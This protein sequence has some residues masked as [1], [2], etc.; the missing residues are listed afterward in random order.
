MT[1]KDIQ[2]FLF[3]NP[4]Y[5]FPDKKIQEKTKE[6]VI[7]GKRIDLLF[8]IDGIRYIVELKNTKL[9]R[10]H[11]GQ[12]IEY[13]GLMKTYLKE[14]NLKLILVAPYIDS[15]QATY[16]EDLGIRC[17]EINDITIQ[18]NEKKEINSERFKKS[19]NENNVDYWVIFENKILDALDSIASSKEKELK[20]LFLYD[21]SYLTIVSFPN[22]PDRLFVKKAEENDYILQ[23]RH[24]GRSIVVIP[25]RRI[26]KIEENRLDKI[27]YIEG[28]KKE[29]S[30]ILNF[31]VLKKRLLEV[32]KNVS[33]SSKS[34]RKLKMEEV[35]ALKK[36]WG[37]L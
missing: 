24:E 2:N 27:F 34:I 29:L 16:L 1:E 4:E 30:Q 3:N 21:D 5:L 28:R 10:E 13:Y 35:N 17:V 8:R 22:K 18:G 37:N 23:I 25:F 36:I 7:N 6:Y 26:I 20:S 11:I 12:L 14:A 9:R 19:I 31:D 33:I 32:D 15:W